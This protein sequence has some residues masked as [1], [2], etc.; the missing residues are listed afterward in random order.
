MVEFSRARILGLLCTAWLLGSCFSSDE[1]Q[2]LALFRMDSGDW[3]YLSD[4]YPLDYV[5]MTG[6]EDLV[7]LESADQQQILARRNLDGRTRWEAAIDYPESS[8]GGCGGA[9]AVSPEGDRIAYL[10]HSQGQ[11]QGQASQTG[12]V[13]VL[14]ADDGLEA[15]RS[16]DWTSD[17]SVSGAYPCANDLA[18][19]SSGEVAVISHNGVQINDLFWL[20]PGHSWAKRGE[21]TVATEAQVAVHRGTGRAAVLASTRGSGLVLSLIEPDGSTKEVLSAGSIAG[22]D[23]SPDGTRL[24]VAADTRLLIID[25]TTGSTRDV[26]ALQTQGL[27]WG[28]ND[29]IAVAWGSEILSVRPDGSDRQVHVELNGGRTA[30]GPLWS[31]DATSLAFVVVPRYR[32]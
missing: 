13:R 4:R 18:W 21:T 32:D 16:P 2:R 19:T 22:F 8:Y 3:R 15:D 9:V 5:W 28:A 17:M 7:L 23:F 20:D 1:T 27:S 10:A 26:G 24:A 31:P 11:A 6:V 30:R 25:A 12:H 14:N 29:R